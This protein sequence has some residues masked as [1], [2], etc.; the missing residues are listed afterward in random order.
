[1]EPAA[2]RASYAAKPPP[3]AD[4]R[5]RHLRRMRVSERMERP[6]A[7]MRHHAGWA[8]VFHIETETADAITGFGF[9]GAALRRRRIRALA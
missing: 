6:W 4:S 3:G 5:R 7:L 2:E 8:D 9:A 1:M